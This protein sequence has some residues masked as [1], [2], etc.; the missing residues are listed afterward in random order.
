MEEIYKVKLD[1]L[2]GAFAIMAN[3]AYTYLTDIKHNYSRWSKEAVDYFGLPSEYMENAGDVWMENVHP[4]DRAIYAASIKEL[5]GGKVSEHNLQY[6]ARTK[7]GKYIVCTCRGVVIRDENGEPGYFGGTIKNND[8]LSYIDDIS[9]FRSLYGFLEDLQSAQW[10]GESIQIMLLGINE[11]S[12][13]ND[14]YG[15]TFGN[16]VLQEFAK[17]ID[18]EAHGMGEWYRM[19]GTKF[20]I[21]CKKSSADDLKN[22]YKRIQYNSIHDFE[23]DGNRIVLSF[24]AGAINLDSLEVSAETVYSCLRFAYYESKNNHLGELFVLKNNVGDDKRFAI[25]RIN[26]IRNSIVN[27]C[28][29][30]FLCYQPIVDATT[31]KIIGAEALIRWKNDEYGVVP[32][33]QFV[34]VLEQ[35]NLFPELGKWILRTA[36]VDA[37]KFLARY[38]GFIVNVN[39]SYTQL[40]KS[41]FVEDVLAII[42]DV[43]FPPQN[44]CLEI[45]ERCRLLDMGLLKDIFTRLRKHGIKVAL[46][47]FGTGFSSIGVLRELPVT[48]VKIDRSFVMNI[49]KNNSDQNTVRFISELADSFSSS[50]TAEGIETPEMRELLLRFKIKSL[51]GFYYSKPLPMDEFMDKYVNA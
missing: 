31:E 25:E 17:M 51:Q 7:D 35:D 49:E 12:R 34:D 20:A 48:T 22:L 1:S 41:D 45:T 26:V 32:P 9:N 10:K 44:L 37:K 16:R 24:V 2:Y 14:I 39:L 28:E 43:N 19:D 15:Y 33:V 40:E 8:T 42:E 3:G 29:G 21:V 36:L 13:L 4:D 50:V 5:F 27:N 18:T 30:F 46:D 38:P 23:V 6:R 11:F 47:D